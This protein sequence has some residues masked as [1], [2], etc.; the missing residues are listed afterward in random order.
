MIKFISD[1]INNFVEYLNEKYKCDEDVYIHIIENC[2]T[3]ESLS[4]ETAYGAY[5]SS[6]DIHRWNH[7]YIAGLCDDE[8]EILDTIAHEYKH[9]IQKYGDKTE[10]SEED[11]DEFSDRVV[12]EYYKAEQ[13]RLSN[14]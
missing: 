6:L 3:L 11:A 5:V 4:G 13:N 2:D 10:F 7:I 1:D 12:K 9:H 14:K 8:S